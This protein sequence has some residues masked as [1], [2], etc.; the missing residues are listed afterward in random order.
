MLKM[1][2]IREY[3]SEWDA[4]MALPQ[5]DGTRKISLEDLIT[6]SL[7]AEGRMRQSGLRKNWFATIYAGHDVRWD[8]RNNVGYLDGE[9]ESAID[10][11][12]DYL[13]RAEP[14]EQTAQA[15]IDE[16]NEEASC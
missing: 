8:G 11:L 3:K 15:I 13:D 16:E 12:A 14:S 10:E 6:Y 5:F 7:E 9:A 2:L 1:R 4:I